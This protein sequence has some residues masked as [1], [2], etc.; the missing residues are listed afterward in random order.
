MLKKGEEMVFKVKK[1]KSQKLTYGT[2]IEIATDNY[3]FYHVD[4]PRWPRGWKV[5]VG[6]IPIRDAP[7]P[8]SMYAKYPNK[9]YVKADLRVSLN[10]DT[11]DGGGGLDYFVQKHS[12][13]YGNVY[14]T[15]EEAMEFGETIIEAIDNYRVELRE[16][17]KTALGE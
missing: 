15:K 12:A 3:E 14:D 11:A 17:Y 6:L 13:D 9:W 5:K 2:W 7:M 8:D 10:I 16:P 1:I 4:L